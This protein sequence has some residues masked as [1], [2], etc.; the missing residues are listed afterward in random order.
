MHTVLTHL[1][2]DFVSRKVELNELDGTPV[3]VTQLLRQLGDGS[4]EYDPSLQSH[5]TRAFDSRQCAPGTSHSQSVS[6]WGEHTVHGASCL[7][8]FDTVEEML[9][10]NREYGEFDSTLDDEFRARAQSPD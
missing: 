8:E 1:D 9:D 5:A 2:G 3:V 4:F 10:W 7:Q 6:V